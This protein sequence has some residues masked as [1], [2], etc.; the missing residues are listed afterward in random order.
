MNEVMRIRAA[1]WS[2][3]IK[4][5]MKMDSSIF[6]GNAGVSKFSSRYLIEAIW[7]SAEKVKVY[8]MTR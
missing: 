8:P 6:I 5:R 3:M 1:N 2:A 7:T 4:Q